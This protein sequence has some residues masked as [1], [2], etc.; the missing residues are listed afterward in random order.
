MKKSTKA[1]GAKPATA[2]AE[3]ARATEPTKAAPR[4]RY[5]GD[6]IATLPPGRGDDPVDLPGPDEATLLPEPRGAYRRLFDQLIAVTERDPRS[7]PTSPLPVLSP[8]QVR[9]VANFITFALVNDLT[10]VDPHDAAVVWEKWR[11]A[12]V[13]LRGLLRDADD[14]PTVRGILT[15]TLDHRVDD[16]SG[17][18]ATALVQ[19]RAV[20]DAYCPWRADWAT[21]ARIHPEAV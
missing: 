17:D 7:S 11:K 12:V 15:L 9:R 21:F 1:K 8:R 2:T 13:T 3:P 5:A 19:P 18:L 14:N 20:F 6:G 16:V 10:S 4:R